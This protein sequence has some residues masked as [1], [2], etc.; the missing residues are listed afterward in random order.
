MQFMGL[1]NYSGYGIVK[2][3][4]ASLLLPFMANTVA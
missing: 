1:F 2:K 4:L 3:A